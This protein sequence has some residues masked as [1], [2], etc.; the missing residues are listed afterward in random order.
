ME[1]NRPT[2]RATTV[3]AVVHKGKSAIGADGQAT[4]G[5]YVVKQKVEKIKTLQGGKIL[6]G[7]AGATADA[8]T[9]L[10]RLEEKLERYA[11]NLK[12]SGLALAKDWR[13]DRY[14]R[15][16]E[17][18]IIALSKDDLLVLSGTGDVLEPEEGIA[19][20]GSGSMYARAAALV[21]KRH[22]PSLSAEDIV[23]EALNIAADICIYTNHN[24]I[25]KTLA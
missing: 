6:A 14:L 4:M 24:F 3:L 12:I 18:M 23:K 13:T 5:D 11:N 20:V 8:F 7:F 25:I 22:K 10:E 2:L 15:R 21:L 19:S 9:L 17:A 16:L 1:T